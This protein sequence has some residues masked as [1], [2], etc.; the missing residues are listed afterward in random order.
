MTTV[1]STLRGHRGSS[2]EFTTPVKPILRKATSVLGTRTRDD[3]EEY[4]AET[5]PTKRR[6]TVMFDESLNVV[7]DIKNKSL[8]DVK[9]EISR[10]LDG[11]AKNDDEDYDTLKEMFTNDHNSGPPSPS[12]GD[13]ETT[14]P[15]DLL[16]YII[17]L[18]AH[19]PMLGKS[20]SG[21]VKSILK[22]YGLR[23][24]TQ[25]LQSMSL[26]KSSP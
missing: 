1:T 24:W 25:L 14:Q 10:A 15:G 12:A 20:C 16:A 8:E 13:D 22:W 23:A 18:T 19:V 6:K 17:A 3:T 11:H 26:T 2:I 4:V 21:L 5:P 7:L 9:R